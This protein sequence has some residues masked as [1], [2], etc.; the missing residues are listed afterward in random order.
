M[1]TH[2]CGEG[3]TSYLETP[4]MWLLRELKRD[5]ERKE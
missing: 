1:D 5:R 4:V 2:A 3:E